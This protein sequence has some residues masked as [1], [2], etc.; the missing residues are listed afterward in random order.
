MLIDN[1]I[2]LYYTLFLES[3]IFIQQSLLTER[4]D[5]KN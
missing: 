5:N 1:P 3:G 4:G 2:F